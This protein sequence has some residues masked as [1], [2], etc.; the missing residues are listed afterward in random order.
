MLH[1]ILLLALSSAPGDSLPAGQ[2]LDDV[3]CAA[4]AS[5]SYALYLPSNYT[6]DREWPVI[7]GFD[8]GGRGR[9]AVERYQ[10]AAEQY[11][12]IIAASNNSRNGSPE[13]G[14]AA[15]SMAND[16][17]SRFHINAK[18]IYTAGMSGGARVAFAVALSSLKVAGV[19]AS[20][21]GYPD[22]KSRGTLP[23]PVFATAGTEDFNHLEMRQLDHELTSP[24]YLAIF[25]GPHVWLSSELA[26]TGVEWMELQAM[27]TGLRSRDE[28]EIDRIFAR[29]MAAA[30]ADK[31]D[32]DTFLALQ[33]I[34]T[35]F[36]GLRDVSAQSVRAAELGRSKNVRDALKK[37]VEEDDREKQMLRSIWSNEARL[38]SAGE[39]ED[40]LSQLRQQ[41][42]KLSEQAKKPDESVD[43]RLARRVLSGLSAAG[44]T[45]DSD[46]LKIIREYRMGRGAR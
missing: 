23:F 26:L 9:N 18:R 29:R 31:G 46:Y 19:F 3:K 22:G 8:P 38:T 4:D 25:Q 10:A 2:I 21:A 28:M 36:K 32:K 16:V 1:L 40:A 35:D 45:T 33:A 6:A 24:H 37:D 41:W 20:S 34:A 42:K 43:R 12:Y 5:Q 7:L 44:N 13:T 17:F 39:H 30:G 14:K 27:K 15:A 11:G